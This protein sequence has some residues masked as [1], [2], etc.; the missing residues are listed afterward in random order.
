MSAILAAPLLVAA[1]ASS[2]FAQA[3]ASASDANLLKRPM[4]FYLAKGGPNACGPGCSEWIAAE[5]QFDVG[6]PNRLRVLLARHR[7]KNLPIYF[8]SSGGLGA[9]AMQIG[10]LLR[11]RGMTAGVSR[12]I[13]E[14]CRDVDEKACWSLKQVA[15]QVLAAELRSVSGCNSACVLALIGAKVRHVPPGAR[16]GVHAS[17]LVTV[18]ASGGVVTARAKE[19]RKRLAEIAAQHRKHMISMGINTRLLDIALS[20]PHEQARYLSRDEI[21]KFGIDAREF[22]ES[23]WTAVETPTKKLVVVKFIVEAKGEKRDEYRTSVIQLSCGGPV[24][25]ALT[26]FR[27]L[28]SEEVGKP[29]KLSISNG[30]RELD[31]SQT[32]ASR[33]IDAF[34]NGGLFASSFDYVPYDYFD[35]AVANGGIDIAQSSPMARSASPRILKFSEQG[36]SDAIQ[37][38]RSNCSK[39]A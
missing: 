1:F 28:A 33:K 14:G 30:R 6:A 11:E 5:G 31:F 3:G 23:T 17:R 38:L 4:V 26:Y 18:Q 24:R 21:V 2:A 39:A 25:V 36:L 34:D 8:Q 27:G 13:P 7:G 35:D 10:R 19:S 20:V 29:A 32:G 22:Q 9:Q 15:G 16:V 37:K 12:T